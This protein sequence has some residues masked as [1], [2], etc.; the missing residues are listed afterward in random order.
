MQRIRIRVA[1]REVRI[2]SLRAKLTFDNIKSPFA[3]YSGGS[4]LRY[5]HPRNPV[6]ACLKRPLLHILHKTHVFVLAC[7]LDQDLG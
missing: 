6:E 2:T 7:M 5:K 4:S 3:L 1:L